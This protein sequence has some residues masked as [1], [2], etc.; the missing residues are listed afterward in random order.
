MELPS[1]SDVA[2]ADDIELQEIMENAARSVEDL[3]EQL[4]G[5]SSET[6]SMRE[7]QGLDKQ[8]R[9]I[10]GSFKVEVAKKVEL[11]QCIEQEKHML[12]IIIDNPKYYDGI[13]EDI[14][15][16]IAKPNDDLP[17]RQK[18]IDLLT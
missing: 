10:K 16:L 13:Q 6:L 4:E 1:A 14:R 12:V 18:S 7:L 3:I 8:L 15:K 2:K 17:V 11:Q 9:G 5:T